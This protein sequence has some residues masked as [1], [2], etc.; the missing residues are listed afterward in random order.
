M[1]DSGIN[2]NTR[3]TQES[4]FEQGI[5]SNIASFWHSREEGYLKSF[6]KTLQEYEASNERGSNHIFS[7]VLFVACVVF[8][9]FCC[10]R[11]L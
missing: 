11:L 8:V 3:Y 4:D 7:C 10:G 9:F 2:I 1:N 5:N 6:D